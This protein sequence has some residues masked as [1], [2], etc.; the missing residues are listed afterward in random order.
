LSASA[1]N[2]S[3]QRSIPRL[4]KLHADAL[5]ALGQAAEAEMALRSAQ[6]MTTAQG[7]RPLLWRI[8][9]TLGALYQTQSRGTEA[10]QA[11]ST[12]RALIEVLAANIPDEH[13]QEQFFHQAEALLPRARATSSPRRAAKQAFGGLTERER[14]VAALIAQG[15]SNREIADQLVVS[16]R[17]VE[18]HVST[19]LSKLAF[20]SR[21]QIAV[22]AVEV[23]LVKQAL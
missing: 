22:W 7:A 10:E 19:I 11:F 12:A 20:S 18:T 16:Y 23:G 4:S 6:E 2:I 21:A 15:K 8:C 13:V 17:T 3:E 14:E 1:A 5:I 9:V